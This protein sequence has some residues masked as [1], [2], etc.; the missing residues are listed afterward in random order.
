[1]LHHARHGKSP[2]CIIEAEYGFSAIVLTQAVTAYVL[3]SNLVASDWAN[4][5]NVSP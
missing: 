5:F 4:D 1:M 3:V 2:V